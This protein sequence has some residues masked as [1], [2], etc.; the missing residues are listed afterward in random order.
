MEKNIMDYKVRVRTEKEKKSYI[1]RLN[2]ISGQINGIKNMMEEDRYCGDVLIQVSAA[3]KA[4]KSFA[5]VVLK[6]H[7]E[8]CVINEIKSGNNKVID[9]AMTLI[10]RLM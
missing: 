10:K 2:K 6:N 8:T 3:D 4:L 7:L 1:T 5:N 9:E